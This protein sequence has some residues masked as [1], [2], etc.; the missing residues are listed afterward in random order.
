MLVEEGKSRVLFIYKY[1]IMNIPTTDW[2]QHTSHIT[3]YQAL[4]VIGG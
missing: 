2:M 4:H 3:N 1:T